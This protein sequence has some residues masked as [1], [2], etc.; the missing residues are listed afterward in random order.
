MDQTR[1][2]QV[3]SNLIQNSIKYSYEGVIFIKARCVY[4]D[5]DSQDGKDSQDKSRMKTLEISVRDQGIGLKDPATIGKMFNQLDV[6]DNVNQ[7]G[8]GF[9]LTITKMIVEQLGGTISFKNHTNFDKLASNLK[10]SE[11]RNNLDSCNED[12]QL[13][14]VITGGYHLDNESFNS[15][16]GKSEESQGLSVI[17]QLPIVTCGDDYNLEEGKEQLG[18]QK[19]F[20]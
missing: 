8:I 5:T 9:G 10:E 3:L 20:S 6:K 14:P 16:E 15:E 1:L 13:N 19:D 18:D 4:S 7:N 2:E 17:L 11:R 12:D